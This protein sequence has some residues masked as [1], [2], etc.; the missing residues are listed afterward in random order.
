MQ[1]NPNLKGIFGANEGSAER[2]GDRRQGIG[3]E[4]RGRSATTPARSRRTTSTRACMAGAITQN[5]VTLKT[6]HA[7]PHEAPGAFAEA[8]LTVRAWTPRGDLFPAIPLDETFRPCLDRQPDQ[9]RRGADLPGLPR[10]S[11]F[12]D[13]AE[14]DQRALIYLGRASRMIALHDADR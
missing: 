12:L 8:V 4:A 13:K 9:Q 10:A 1:A 2:R 6:G 5:P 3:Q 14:R 11:I 7:L